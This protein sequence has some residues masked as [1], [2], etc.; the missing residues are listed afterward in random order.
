[1]NTQPQ[2]HTEHFCLCPSMRNYVF[3]LARWS[4]SSVCFLVAPKQLQVFFPNSPP[5]VPGFSPGLL[6]QLPFSFSTVFCLSG[7]ISCEEVRD[8]NNIHVSLRL[9]YLCSY[10]ASLPTVPLPHSP[11]YLSI[12]RCSI[13]PLKPS[14]LSHFSHCLRSFLTPL[15][16]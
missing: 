16:R 8:T 3:F 14:A 6:S 10:C 15:A 2:A 13:C 7:W 12:H 9:C 11:L 4:S 5:S 1:M